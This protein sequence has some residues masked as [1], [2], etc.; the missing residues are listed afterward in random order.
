MPAGEAAPRTE[1]RSMRRR[2][3]LFGSL[4]AACGII[5]GIVLWGGFHTAMEATNRLE[6]C[7]SCHE[8]QSP[9]FAEYSKSPHYTNAAGVRAICSDCHVP[10]EWWPKIVR[11]VY[12]SKDLYHHILGT[13]DT[14]QKFEAQRLAMAKRVWDQMAA[15]DSQE[16]RNC[17][18]FQA[19]DFAKQRPNS[20]KQ[21]HAAA[22]RNETCIGCHK[23]IAHR[24]PD[25]TQ[26]IRVAYEELLR[27][28]AKEGAQ[29]DAL[30]SVS[31]KPLFL[32]RPNGSAEG[33]GDA[34]LLGLTP[35]RVVERQGDWLKIRIEGWQQEG[36]E[37]VVYAQ[38]GKRIFVAALGPAAVEKVTRIG[39][40]T[41][42][43][44]DLVWHQ[45]ALTMWTARAALI[46]DPAK[47]NAYG[48]ELYV[49]SCGTCHAPHPTNHL[50]ANQWIGGLNSMKNRV[51]LDDEQYRFLQKYL[52][53][54]AQDTGGRT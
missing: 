28:A 20:A 54:H 43:D 3:W 15:N 53:L 41:D 10:R 39:T 52:Q 33:N 27:V 9:S 48:A 22:E 45:V 29:Q 37:R 25:M 18:S 36:A 7:V 46:G 34:R 47:L 35:V 2:F 21:M 12:A 16:C 31:T 23:G 17:H 5:A 1:R 49:D 32:D 50:L 19:M 40:E 4:I 13:L 8:M 14:P 6:F 38:R 30:W 51:T 44:T 26:G 11:K 42:P 24:L